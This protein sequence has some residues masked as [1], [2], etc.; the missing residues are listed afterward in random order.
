[1][2][3]SNLDALVEN[4]LTAYGLDLPNA[5]LRRF[6]KSSFR[7]DFIARVPGGF[8]TA[9]DVRKSG[10]D[11]KALYVLYGWWDEAVSR[12][13]I[14]RLLLVTPSP[15]SPEDL[16]RFETTFEADEN[17]RWIGIE[18]LPGILGI[19]DQLDL[20]SPE[21]LDRLKTASLTRKA[22]NYSPDVVGVRVVEEPRSAVANRLAEL[23]VPKSLARQL[24]MKTLIELARKGEATEKTLRFGEEIRVYGFLSDIKSFSTLV[25]VGDPSAVQEMMS[26]Y[27]RRA[28]EIIWSHHGVLDKFIGDA[29]LAIWGYPEDTERDGFN[30]VRAAVDLVDLGRSL[31]DEFQSRHNE[32]IESG[33]R[34]GIASD[35]VLVLNIGAD[36]AEISFVGN[37]INL[38][39]RLEAA[40]NV[41]GI[42]MDNRT[43]ASLQNIDPELHA[44]G[45]ASQR[46]L[47]Q[48]H[49]KGQL[50]S[51]RAW[52]INKDGVQRMLQA[53]SPSGSR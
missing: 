4:L 3:E 33:T 41:D 43:H 32:V 50:T 39:A 5:T 29:V 20:G 9:I 51:I 48:Q 52:Q 42:L 11:A 17:V 25:R 34:V 44:C 2:L 14:D 21:T 36:Q 30:A 23:K 46:V 49:A 26:S 35:E 10:V 38:A 31:L 6:G 15:P 19:R 53:R 8:R 7:P 1:M 27:Y 13:S 16:E 28:R 45:G 37:A 40:C 22:R 24:S 18:D 47:D 12:R